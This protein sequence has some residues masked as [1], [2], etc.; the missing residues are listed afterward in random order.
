VI[1]A[2]GRGDFI[3]RYFETARDLLKRGFAVACYD[4]RGQGGSQ[5][6]FSNSYRSAVKSFANY[7]DD[8]AAVMTSAVLPECPPPYYLLAHSTGALISL[9]A[10]RK[11]TWFDKAVFTSP[12]LGFQTGLWPIPVARA[13]AH[14]VPLFGGAGAFLPG[15]S[16]KPLVLNGFDGNPFTSDPHRFRRDRSILDKQPGLG[17]GG[18]TFGWLRAAMNCMDEVYKMDRETRLKAPI[19][20]VA[21][22]LDEVVD[23]EA[24]RRFCE[25]AAGLSFTVIDE[26]KHE[27]LMERDP[28]RHQFFAA[29]DT[30]ID[31]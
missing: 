11:R 10:L 28:I 24:A 12:L 3:E 4:F 19:L 30:F 18:P 7:E 26:A 27:I 23:T 22:G 21:A 14:A 9:R 25:Q 13:L 5:R 2:Q 17:L 20:V 6:S 29:F 16:H 8:L 31:A 1:I 15:Y